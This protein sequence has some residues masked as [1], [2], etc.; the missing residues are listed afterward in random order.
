M[1]VGDL[2]QMK[3]EDAEDSKCAGEMAEAN[4]SENGYEGDSAECDHVAD[5][6]E[7]ED[8]IEMTET[9]N[10]NSSTMYVNDGDMEENETNNSECVNE[11]DKSDSPNKFMEDNDSSHTPKCVVEDE[12]KRE[13]KQDFLGDLNTALEVEVVHKPVVQVVSSLCLDMGRPSV[14]RVRPR[15]RPVPGCGDTAE[16]FTVRHQRRGSL[17]IAD[18]Q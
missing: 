17:V 16:V 18:C 3:R 13:D 7:A 10:E 14:A 5:I 15:H 6:A 9:E 1:K 8:T 11:E 4:P 12:D 2:V